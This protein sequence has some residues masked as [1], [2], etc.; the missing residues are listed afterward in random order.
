MLQLTGIVPAA[1]ALMAV[2]VAAISAALL[3][4]L[5]VK[6]GT[7]RNWARWVFVAIYVLGSLISMIV[8]AVAPQMFMAIPVLGRVS[9]VT[10]FA[11]QTTAL[12]FMFT[13][14]SRQWFGAMR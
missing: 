1:N 13:R 6:V 8:F 4:L 9:A 7:G 11:L 14:A 3:A 5:A 2:G 10:Q 12:M